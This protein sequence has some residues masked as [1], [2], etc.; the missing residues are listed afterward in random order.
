MKKIQLKY[1]KSLIQNVGR[2]LY[3]RQCRLNREE[4]TFAVTSLSVI[5]LALY[6]IVYAMI[7]VVDP[8]SFINYPYTFSYCLILF[9]AS[10]HAMLISISIVH[11]RIEFIECNP[12][13]TVSL[14]IPYL[15]LLLLVLLLA[16]H[17]DE[18]YLG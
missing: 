3:D 9:L 2:V 15:K 4:F 11:R 18:R 12:L 5:T 7:A 1:C 14:F 16:P 13:Y 10:I 8:D 6:G 17:G